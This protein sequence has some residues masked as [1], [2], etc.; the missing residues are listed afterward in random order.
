MFHDGVVEGI[1]TDRPV[2]RLLD[3]IGYQPRRDARATHTWFDAFRTLKFIHAAREEFPDSPLIATLESLYPDTH[4]PAQMNASLRA[5][6][7][8]LP[9]RKGLG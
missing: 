1:E 8:R 4:T 2:P 9:E 5:D 6:E 3:A 7:S